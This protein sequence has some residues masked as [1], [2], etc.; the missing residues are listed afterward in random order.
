LELQD[1]YLRKSE[2]GFAYI[3]LLRA[4]GTSIYH[5]IVRIPP[6]EAHPIPTY[7]RVLYYMVLESIDCFAEGIED[8]EEK[9]KH[10]KKKKKKEE[11]RDDYP[12]DDAKESSEGSGHHTEGT[13]DDTHRTEEQ[14]EE[15]EKP[16]KEKKKK[17]KKKKDK[18]GDKKDS[19]GD[20]NHQHLQIAAITCKYLLCCR[21]LTVMLQLLHC[22]YRNLQLKQL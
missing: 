18:E 9:K 12:K 4:P 10:K 3:P 2:N 22:K 20:E 5:R 15:G 1:Q 6:G 13:S 17:H 8:K 19:G 11:H 14:Q 21:K 16:E 7:G